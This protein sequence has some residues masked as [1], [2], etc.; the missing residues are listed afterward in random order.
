GGADPRAEDT[1]GKSDVVRTVWSYDPVTCNWLR[2][3]EMLTP[4][5]NFGLVV[6]GGKLYAIG[7]QDKKGRVLSS[8]ECFNPTVGVWE[9]MSSLA[10]GRMGMAATKFRDFIWVAGGMMSL[11]STSLSSDVECYDTRRNM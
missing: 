8:V 5:K 9:E 7:G 3:T 10:V 1:T 6:S 4:R 2:E 11:K